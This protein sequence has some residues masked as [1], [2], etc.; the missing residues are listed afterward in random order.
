MLSPFG[1]VGTS[2]EEARQTREKSRKGLVDLPRCAIEE[3]RLRERKS[4]G[5]GAKVEEEVV[6]GGGFETTR[7][8]WTAAVECGTAG[9]AEG[10]RMVDTEAPRGRTV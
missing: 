7:A 3:A 10:G 1:G 9:E 8:I 4:E 2:R 6:E 5:E